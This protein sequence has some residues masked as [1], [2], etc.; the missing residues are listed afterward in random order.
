M[1]PTSH[2]ADSRTH[3]PTPIKAWHVC[4]SGFTQHLGRPNGLEVLWQQLRS[5]HHN[6]CVAVELCAWNDNWQHVAEFIWRFRP[7]HIRPQIYIYAYSW[8]G[9]WGFPSLARELRSRGLQVDAAVLSDAVYRHWYRAG[10]W[11]AYAPWSEIV[12]PCNVQRVHWFYQRQTR[13]RGHRVVAE[14]GDS[15]RVWGGIELEVDHA[16]MDDAREF[17]E[18]SL[19]VAA[20]HKPPPH[21]GGPGR[22]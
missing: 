13:L 11:R 7:P 6:G 12:V 20:G 3:V 4:I 19:A 5:R 21:S 14:D 22:G 10:N 1:I 9:G 15:T 2:A 18:L 17:H 8:G 16:Y